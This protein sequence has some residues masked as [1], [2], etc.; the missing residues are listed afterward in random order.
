MVGKRHVSPEGPPVVRFDKP[1]SWRYFESY[2]RILPLDHGYAVDYFVFRNSRAA[3]EV[4]EQLP[5][6]IIGAWRWDNS[7]LALFLKSNDIA[8]I[9]ATQI[10]PTVHQVVNP[11][12]HHEQRRGAEYN[13]QLAER[14][15]GIDFWFGSID[16]A[17]VALTPGMTPDQ[18]KGAAENDLWS[19]C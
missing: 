12:T 11:V 13:E 6:F 17:D 10:S 18:V 16:N 3:S 19:I 14:H 15:I 5:P 4:V 7:L 1:I 2:A 9:D 8:V